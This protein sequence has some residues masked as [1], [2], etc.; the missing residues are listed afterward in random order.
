MVFPEFVQTAFEG[1]EGWRCHNTFRKRVLLVPNP[2]GEVACSHIETRPLLHIFT[3][4]Y[5]LDP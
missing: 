5:D 4:P 2:L 1:V 3:R